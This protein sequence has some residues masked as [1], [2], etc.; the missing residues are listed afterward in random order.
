[1]YDMALQYLSGEAGTTVHTS[2][3]E[4]VLYRNSSFLKNK[5]IGTRSKILPSYKLF[6]LLPSVHKSA[7]LN[8][9]TSDCITDK[10]VSYL[11]KYKTRIFIS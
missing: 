2:W 5:P 6:N 11:S 1:M 4:N 3:V 7:S 10:K 8:R 9:S